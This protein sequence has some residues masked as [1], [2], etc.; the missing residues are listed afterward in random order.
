VEA[1]MI[2]SI[3]LAGIILKIG[4]VFV[5]LFGYS[6][7]I[8][9]IGLVSGVLLMFRSDGKVVMAY[10]SVMHMSLCGVVIG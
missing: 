1:S 9:I 8:I 4:I 6:I 5:G 10:S 7:P 2:R 3:I